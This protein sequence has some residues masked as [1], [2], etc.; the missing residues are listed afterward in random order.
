MQKVPVIN[1]RMR[2]HEWAQVTALMLSPDQPIVFVGRD[3]C[4]LLGISRESGDGRSF[5]V[6]VTR[7]NLTRTAVF[8]R[9]G[10]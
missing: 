2:F 4:V 9:V 1:P 6:T 8:V 3:Q 7:P 10:D 5:I